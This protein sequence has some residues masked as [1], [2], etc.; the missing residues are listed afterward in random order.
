MYLINIHKH[1]IIVDCVALLSIYMKRLRL[2]RETR[3]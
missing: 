3:K 2:V 1:V